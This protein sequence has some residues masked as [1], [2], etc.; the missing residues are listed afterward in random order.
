MARQAA[1]GCGLLE[2]WP[3]AVEKILPIHKSL[4]LLSYMKVLDIPI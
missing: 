2:K 3:K 4:Q 1:G